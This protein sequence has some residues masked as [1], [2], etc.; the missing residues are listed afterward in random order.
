MKNKNASIWQ[1][2]EI[3]QEKYWLNINGFITNDPTEESVTIAQVFPNAQQEGAVIYF[4]HQI[5]NDKYGMSA[6]KKAQDFIEN[7]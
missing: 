6:I 2:I 1:K 7:N 3:R 5:K 4:D